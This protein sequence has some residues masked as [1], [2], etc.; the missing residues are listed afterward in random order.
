MLSDARSTPSPNSGYSMAAAAGSLGIQLIKPGVYK[1]G[2]PKNEL[3]P[4]MIKKAI[5]LTIITITLFLF[6]LI[7]ILIFTFLF[8]H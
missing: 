4:G 3:K 5:K 8:F 7:I 2:Y 6:I 1:L